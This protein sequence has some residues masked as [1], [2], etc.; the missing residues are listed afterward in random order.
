MNLEL[1]KNNMALIENCYSSIAQLN[2]EFSVEIANILKAG[3]ETNGR[4]SLAVSG[5]RTP[6]AMFN[7]LSNQSL[8]WSKV[9]IA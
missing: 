1:G 3:I 8:D 2:E 5:G 6:A 4:A 7:Q 9:S